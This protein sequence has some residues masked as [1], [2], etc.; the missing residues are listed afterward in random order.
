[1]TGWIFHACGE[2]QKN[3]RRVY[4]RHGT[5]VV[6]ELLSLCLFYF[7]AGISYQRSAEELIARQNVGIRSKQLFA[8]PR[9][10][11]GRT[12]TTQEKLYNRSPVK[13]SGEPRGES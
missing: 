7:R 8:A 3:P 11:P 1:M 13:P 12:P 6:K 2:L 9:S 4:S 10:S 5:L